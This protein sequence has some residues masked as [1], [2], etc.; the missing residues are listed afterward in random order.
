MI[1]SLDRGEI[2]E[3]KE[4]LKKVNEI[5]AT[6]LREYDMREYKTK[7][8]HYEMDADILL[9]PSSYHKFIDGHTEILLDFIKRKNGEEY[10][11]I[12][13]AKKEI[14]KTDKETIDKY[15]CKTYEKAAETWRDEI[16]KHINKIQGN[17][18]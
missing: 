13:T 15:I 9:N 14:G 8:Q 1:Q 18:Y 12:T 5:L 7:S 16:N 6:G 10:Y 11:L 17:L 4:L 2:E 3:A